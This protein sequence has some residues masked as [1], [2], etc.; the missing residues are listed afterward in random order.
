MIDA[1]AGS[2]HLHCSIRERNR[3]R[4]EAEI[5]AT[6]A[7]EE[8]RKRGIQREAEAR[9]CGVAEAKAAAAMARKEDRLKAD[10]ELKVALATVAKRTA[11]AAAEARAAEAE[12]R[13][14]AA[15]EAATA[16]EELERELSAARERAVKLEGGKWQR[17]SEEAEV[18]A[19]AENVSGDLH[20]SCFPGCV[21]LRYPDGLSN[22]TQGR[23][24]REFV[25]NVAGGGY[26]KEVRLQIET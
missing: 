26:V 4:E 5:L 19:A 18:R 23:S 10:E 7:V 24:G 11:E 6:S 8:E 1:H 14:Q 25:S 15:Q 20:D 2:V 9:A 16:K 22:V 21:V 3:L 13:R 17:A 12:A